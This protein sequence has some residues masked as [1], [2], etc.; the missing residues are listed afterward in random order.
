MT[1]GALPFDGKVA[2]VTGGAGA[3]GAAIA[4]AL[5]KA[6]AAV[7]LLDRQRATKTVAAIVAAGG[8]ALDL[9][10]DI[11]DKA[12]V[13]AAVGRAVAAFGGLDILVNAAGITSFGSAASLEEAEWDRVIAINLKGVFLACQA[14]IPALKARGGGRIVNIGSVLAKNGGNARPW[15]NP[16]E[17]SRAGNLAYGASK[18]GVHALTL[19]LA[20]ELAGAKITVNAVAPGPIASAMTT[21][22][23]DA[24]KAL[25]PAGRMGTTGDVAQA[26][27][28]LAGPGASFVT[29]EILDVNGGLW[30]D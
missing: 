26:V 28:Y 21:E 3:I 6:G 23:P 24:L 1:A 13:N 8:R 17:Q 10:T 5:A 25:I 4:I 20:R 27:L 14:V 15:L 7:A 19:Y 22:F 18:A 12:A 11:T 2:F 29:G 16:D 30:A 9:P